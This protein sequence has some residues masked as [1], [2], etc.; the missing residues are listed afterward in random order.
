MKKSNLLIAVVFLC[1]CNQPAQQS[2]TYTTETPAES[3]LRQDTL[4][5]TIT[6]PDLGKNG[7]HIIYSDY[8]A[9]MLPMEKLERTFS[10]ENQEIHIKV[11]HAHVGDNLFVEIE[12]SEPNGNVQI[13]KIIRP[14]GSTDGPF[15]RE[16]TYNVKEEGDYTFIFKKNTRA[17]GSIK[18]DVLITLIKKE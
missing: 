6:Q 11:Q 2:N 4:P 1:A 5:D 10:N 13:N 17:S 18:G 12:H 3:V 8:P 7:E 14:N 9:D 15:G 16:L